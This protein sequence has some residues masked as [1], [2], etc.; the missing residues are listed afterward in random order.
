MD[1]NLD[2]IRETT[3]A[4]IERN[5]RNYKLMFAVVG[6]IEIAFLAAFLLLADFSNR[7]HLLLLI[8]SISVYTII[9]FGLF[10]LGL[11]VN[12]NALRIINAIES[13]EDGKQ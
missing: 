4:R 11:H 1:K 7:V 9:G 2:D 6:A 13:I 3:L 5:E 8:S 10:A 12:Q